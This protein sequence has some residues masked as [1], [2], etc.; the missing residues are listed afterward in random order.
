MPVSAKN[1]TAKKPRF[2]AAAAF[3]ESK[4]WESVGEGWRQLHG[5]YRERGFSFEWHDFTSQ[6]EVDWGQSFHP[7]SA[8]I[9]LNLAGRGFV[10]EGKRKLEFVP[11]TAG[12]Y[13]LNKQSLKATRA[14]NERHQ[15]LTVEL[16]PAFLRK[17]FSGTE[18]NLHP[19][20]QGLVRNTE[21]SAISE[22][23]RLTADHQ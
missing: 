3:S 21:S 15:F 18:A 23:I 12:F 10:A 9:C 8:E 1:A 19:I 14:A 20:V 7:G 5:S 11:M 17:H 6:R 4:A 16:S 13:W 2:E 22:L